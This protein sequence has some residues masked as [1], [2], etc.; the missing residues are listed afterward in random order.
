MITQL[1]VADPTHRLSIHDSILSIFHLK[2]QN[3]LKDFFDFFIHSAFFLEDGEIGAS[4][5][6][7]KVGRSEPASQV[8]KS[9]RVE[10]EIFPVVLKS[11]VE[12]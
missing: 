8:Q 6:E 5:S 9:G 12:V 1:I 4:A 2:R 3:L 7:P 10:A 11:K